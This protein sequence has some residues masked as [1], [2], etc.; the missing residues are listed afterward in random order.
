L[1][2][3][4]DAQ[5]SDKLLS[6]TA[7]KEL[8]DCAKKLSEELYTNPK[9]AYVKLNDLIIKC[10]N[11]YPYRKHLLYYILNEIIFLKTALDKKEAYSPSE[12][13]SFQNTVIQMFTDLRQLMLTPKS[14]NFNVKYSAVDGK[15]PIIT[16]N[17]LVDNGVLYNKLCK[18][19]EL[20]EELF[21]QF[22]LSLNSSKLN[23]IEKAENICQEHQ[24]NLLTNQLEEHEKAKKVSDQ[25]IVELTK[26][27]QFLNKVPNEQVK[28]LHKSEDRIR[29]LER[30]VNELEVNLK[31]LKV[32]LET[33]RIP[34]AQ[35]G[36]FWRPFFGLYA[37]HTGGSNQPN[38]DS[39]FETV[40]P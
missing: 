29:E 26:Q 28:Q 16:L 39:D 20:L 18:S 37:P 36:A 27:L 34:N 33:R 11:S 14:S 4:H 31:I 15:E 30:E 12:F 9:E 13:V 5:V 32:Q 35:K 2:R 19:G 38:S 6:G 3:Y 10:T 7:P 17:G 22:N 23:F 8:I 25:Q 24:I 1:I 40:T 21:N